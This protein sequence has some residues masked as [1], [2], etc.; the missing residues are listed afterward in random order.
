MGYIYLIQE[1]EFLTQN[2]SVYKIGKST[3]ENCRRL[4]SYPKG[5]KLIFCN[6]VNECHFIEKELIRLLKYKFIWR[7]DLG[8]EYFEGDLFKI[9][10]LLFECINI[11]DYKILPIIHT[12]IENIF[13]LIHYNPLYPE[14]CNLK[15]FNID[16]KFIDVYMNDKWQ[17][18]EENIIIKS[19]I[20]KL[21]ISFRELINSQ[22]STKIDNKLN[23]SN[24][25]IIFENLDTNTNFY[26]ELHNSMKKTIYKYTKKYGLYER[27]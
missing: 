17:K 18:L 16:D 13:I 23:I 21:Y 2:L 3:Q 4:N 24:I 22:L 27:R 25:D 8:N 20:K 26:I 10:T 15:L 6:E 7:N 11:Y 5:S 14:N 9:K 19:S 12:L 1:R